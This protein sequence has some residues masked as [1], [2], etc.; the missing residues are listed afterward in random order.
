MRIITMT[1]VEVVRAS[2]CVTVVVHLFCRVRCSSVE[3]GV[4]RGLC[5]VWLQTNQVELSGYYPIQPWAA[6]NSTYN[7]N[8]GCSVKTN[9]TDQLNLCSW[10]EAVCLRCPRKRARARRASRGG[11][12]LP[13][14]RYCSRSWTRNDGAN[15]RTPARAGTKTRT[16]THTGARTLT[17]SLS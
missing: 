1:F 6:S 11:T 8:S 5:V 13:P 7:P 2:C 12:T 17:R 3:V 9:A 16:A 14:L 10:Q 15:H 4:E